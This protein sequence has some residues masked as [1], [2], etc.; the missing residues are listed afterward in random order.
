MTSPPDYPWTADT[1]RLRL[2]FVV[3]LVSWGVGLFALLASS[4]P[5]LTPGLYVL[6]LCLV[7]YVP[8]TVYAYRVQKHLN[9]A[10]LYPHGA[11]QVIVGAILLNPFVFGFWI[12]A[13]VLWSAR[14]ITRGSPTL[15]PPGSPTPYVGPQVQLASVA[16]VAKATAAAHANARWTTYLLYG[17]LALDVIAIVSGL[18]QRGL[19]LRIAAGEHPAPGVAEANDARQAAI[20]GSQVLAFVVTGIVWL[21]WLYRA[22]NNLGAVGVKKARFSPGWAVGYWFVPFVNLVRPYQIVVDLWQRSEGLNA[23]DSVEH[24]PRP[25]I[26]SWWWGVYLLSAFAARASAS[27]ISDA[28]TAQDFITAT[29]LGVVEDGI[30][31][32]AALLAVAVVRGIDQRQQR[33]A[34]SGV[35]PTWA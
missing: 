19:L 17:C 13:S 31:V 3:Y 10:G 28:H 4:G 6:L 35:P 14:R 20:G 16:D 23:S 25:P 34:V 21:V 8:C 11:W 32:I 27:L 15:A 29:N 30:G 26:I 24:L 2:W 22:Y 5:D 12:P 7:P 33:F 1:R 9:A 18:L